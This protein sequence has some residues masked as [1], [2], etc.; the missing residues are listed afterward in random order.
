MTLRCLL[1]K[2]RSEIPYEEFLEHLCLIHPEAWEEIETWPDHR[3]VIIDLTLQ[4]EDFKGDEDAT[5]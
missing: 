3:S 2:R 1:C 5:T 4:P